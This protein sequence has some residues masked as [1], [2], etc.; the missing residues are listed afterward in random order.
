MAEHQF[1]KVYSST[2]RTDC[3]Q[4]IRQVLH[5][6]LVGGLKASHLEFYFHTSTSA[7]NLRIA[8][9]RR[10]ERSA[11]HVDFRG[12]SISVVDRLHL[13]SNGSLTWR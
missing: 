4:D 6:E 11:L 3:P 12:R 2:L 7:L 9:G 1:T 13:V 5:A 8:V 10:H